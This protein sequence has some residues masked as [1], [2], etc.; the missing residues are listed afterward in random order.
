MTGLGTGC[1]ALCGPTLARFVPGE[2]SGVMVSPIL[3]GGAA[4]R[5]A[6][7]TKIGE[8]V[9]PHFCGWKNLQTE[10]QNGEVGR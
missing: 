7:R 5:L 1:G 6:I 2:R 4:H 10:E 8:C 3:F 9:G